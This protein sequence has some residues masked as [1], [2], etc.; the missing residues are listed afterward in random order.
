MSTK[1]PES[2]L[3]GLILIDKPVGWTSHDVVA[4]ARRITGQRRIGHTGTLDPMA[5]GLL[6]L[7]LGQATRLVEYLTGHDKRYTGEIVLG[8]TT[9]TDDA[10]GE[11]LEARPVPAVTESGLRDLERRFT[12]PILQ[13]PPAFSAIK[14]AGK[15]AYAVA[16]AGDTPRLEPR[17]VAVHALSLAAVSPGRLAIELHCGP[18]T[19][20]RSLARDIGAALGCG[21]H[22]GSLRRHSAGPF[23][24][25]AATSLEG[26]EAAEETG[27]FD[28]ILLHAD[29]GM[30][31]HEAAILAA[32]GCRRFAHG[33]MH[34][35]SSGAE[36]SAAVARIY[37][38][39][40]EFL[41]VGSVSSL[42]EIRP[43]KVL[44]LPN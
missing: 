26:L 7:C 27:A 39:S 36:M 17:A 6:V 21:G 42:G 13:L 5:T 18:G 31:G 43:V 20:V 11:T 35:S 1:R 4:K 19:Y 38:T 16:R 32:D 33:L 41:G 40:G 44:N 15:R 30:R 10:E 8:R 2:P 25:E 34:H 9:T 24:V 28:D 14:V 37:A 3:H 12:G 22:L 29:E 23:R